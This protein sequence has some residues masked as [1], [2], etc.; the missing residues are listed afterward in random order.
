MAKEK[1]KDI[2]VYA[3]ETRP[4]MQGSRL[5]TYELMKAGIHTTLLTDNMAGFFMK[6]E[7]VDIIITGADRIASNGDSANKIG[8]YQLAVL[9]KH[10]NIP[11]YIAAPGSTFDFELKTGDEIPIEFREKEEMT[12]FRGVQSAPVNVEV[13]SPAFDVTPASLI[14]GIITNKGVFTAP[15]HFTPDLFY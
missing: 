8:T 7:K 11:F 1:G 3:M 9:A 15:Y 10:H 12:H 5:T 14:S 2:Q 4:L 13:F 6:K